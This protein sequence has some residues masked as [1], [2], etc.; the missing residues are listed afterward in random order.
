[1]SRLTI[2]ESADGYTDKIILS[3]GDFTT[4]AGNTTTLVNIPVKKGDVIHGAALNISEAF[5]VS[6]NLSVGY[7]AAIDGS[8]VKAEGL[9]LNSNVNTVQIKVDTGLG[10]SPTIDTS[11]SSVTALKV[12]AAA[13]GNITVT[14]ASALDVSTTGELTL[15]LAI[16]RLNA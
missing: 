13:D 10:L 6:S 1:M 5:S 3:P 2:N 12:V 8:G 14:S 15:Q 4:A 11:G 16:R 9:I 7:D